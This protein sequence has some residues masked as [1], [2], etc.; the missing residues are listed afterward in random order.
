MMFF[1][2]SVWFWEERVYMDF[3]FIKQNKAEK[4]NEL[5]QFSIDLCN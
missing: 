3:I 1:H 5:S 2:V 4:F